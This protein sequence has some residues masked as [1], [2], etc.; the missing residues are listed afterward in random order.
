MAMTLQVIYPIAEGTRF[1][2]DYYLETHLPLVSEHMGAHLQGATASRGVAGGA[3][4]SPA[5]NYVI[6]T[7]R[8]ADE[9]ALTAAL[10][11]AGPVIADIPNFTD[12]VPQMTVGEVIA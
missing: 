10:A 12:T 1:D 4:D 3:P 8:F 9:A 6:A 7:L 11:V 2:Y 5:P